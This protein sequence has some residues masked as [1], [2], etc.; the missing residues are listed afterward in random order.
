MTPIERAREWAKRR[1]LKT[2]EI[3]KKEGVAIPPTIQKKPKVRPK[4][5]E[6]PKE[7][8]VVEKKAAIETKIEEKPV[9]Q[10]SV[11][12]K[13]KGDTVTLDELLF[14]DGNNVVKIA[15]RQKANRV[16]RMQIFL[17][18]SL[19]LRPTTYVGKCSAMNFWNLLKESLKR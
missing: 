5:E 10:E 15:L 13:E 4:R 9:Q 19:E 12:I 11:E 8:R 17:N 7:I 16:C 2:K 14:S 3:Q 1:D 6:T 18:D